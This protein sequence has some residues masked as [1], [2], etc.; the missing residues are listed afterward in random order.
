[1]TKT[2]QKTI[3]LSNMRTRLQIKTFKT[4]QAMYEF[5]NKQPNNDWQP[6]EKDLKSGL[7]AYA[8]GVWHNV[9]SLDACI[10]SHI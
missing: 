4:S 1:M 6:S 2:V 3:N 8:G 7:Y 9:K 10:L 5:L